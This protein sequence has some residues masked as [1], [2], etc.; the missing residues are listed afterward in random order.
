MY[1]CYQVLI[2]YMS[3]DHKLAGRLQEAYG[4]HEADEP[5]VEVGHAVLALS[6]L[7]LLL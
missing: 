5:P 4:G 6:L 3:L 7:S 1:N 2:I